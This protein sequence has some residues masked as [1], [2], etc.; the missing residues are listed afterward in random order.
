M[1]FQATYAARAGEWSTQ[2][3]TTKSENINEYEEAY[4]R[5]RGEGSVQMGQGALGRPRA[6]AGGSKVTADS[7]STCTK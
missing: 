1:A 2:E 6:S 5:I 3:H 4:V 7:G